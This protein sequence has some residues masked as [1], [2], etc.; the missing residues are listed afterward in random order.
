MLKLLTSLASVK[1]PVGVT[2]AMMVPLF[3]VLTAKGI[4]LR[5]IDAKYEAALASYNE[6][7]K[8]LIILRHAN[9][10]LDE[11]IGRQ[12][13]SVDSL[14]AVQSVASQRSDSALRVARLEL[15]RLMRDDRTPTEPDT[16]LTWRD[17][18]P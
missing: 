4:A 6:C 3:L 15:D 18:V 11:T 8:A 7:D 16:G 13:R 5:K 10:T 9:A 1:M 12:N 2:V 14:I 17:L